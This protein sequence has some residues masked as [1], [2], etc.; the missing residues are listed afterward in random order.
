MGFTGQTADD[1][2]TA[3]KQQKFNDLISFCKGKFIRI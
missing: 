2:F 3:K 1:R